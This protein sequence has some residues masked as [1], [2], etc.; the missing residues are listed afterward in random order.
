MRTFITALLATSIIASSGSDGSYYYGNGGEAHV[1]QNG[2]ALTTAQF[3]DDWSNNTKANNVCGRAS[4]KE[5]SPI[6]LKSSAEDT[7]L[8]IN[9]SI[10]LFDYDGST[11]DERADEKD[12]A[13]NWHVNLE[14]LSNTIMTRRANDLLA[15][16][17]ALQFH[18]HTPS[19]HTVDG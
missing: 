3:N 15:D 7:V 13:T 19:E 9:A 12:M 5:Q 4:S 18:I 10:N 11:M 8:D 2:I 16:Y 1:K 6:N 14:P 17:R